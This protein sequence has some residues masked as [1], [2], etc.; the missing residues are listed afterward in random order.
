L[1][2]TNEAGEPQPRK[3]R[4]VLFIG[5][6][7]EMK[8]K[9]LSLLLAL[10]MLV[11]L[12]VPALAEETEEES[13][14]TTAID[15]VFST[16]VF[17]EAWNQE[18]TICVWFRE[19][20]DSTSANISVPRVNMTLIVDGEPA[21]LE[22]YTTALNP[23]GVSNVLRFRKDLSWETM[24]FT[25]TH[26]GQTL[27]HEFTNSR[28]FSTRVF[29]EAW[30]REP[31][32]CVWFREGVGSTSANISVPRVNMTLIVD[33]YPVDLADYTT[34]LNPAGVSNVLRFRKN[35][36]WQTM[37]FTVTHNGQTLTH[38]FINN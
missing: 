7:P 24:V 33:G 25:V 17:D 31:T 30:D 20:D 32:F 6:F 1:G 37:V 9:L 18:R 2:V 5:G 34:A 35:L 26:N 29:D 11:A 3:K 12:A 16:R 21:N 8:K 27:T 15:K 19:G 10:I 28:F 36:D 22:E 13:I 23:A 4:G 14:T 38:E